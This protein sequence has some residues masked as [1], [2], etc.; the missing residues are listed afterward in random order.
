MVVDG[1]LRTAT[2]DP[3]SDGDEILELLALF[4]FNIFCRGVGS[5]PSLHPCLRIEEMTFGILRNPAPLFARA[6]FCKVA[7][8][9]SCAYKGPA[10]RRITGVPTRKRT[11]LGPYR[12]PM[13]RVLGGSY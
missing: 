11:P 5:Y 1:T 10:S 6:E 2:P 13:P 3:L 4:V 8:T 7:E 12:R 9:A